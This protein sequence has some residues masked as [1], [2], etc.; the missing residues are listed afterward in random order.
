MAFAPQRF[1]LLRHRI[2]VE[3][4]KSA[5]NPTQFFT[6]LT[7]HFSTLRC[8]CILTCW[9]LFPFWLGHVLRAITACNFSLL[10]WP[11]GSA[12]RRFSEPT[13]RS[14]KTLEKYGVSRLCYLFA[15]LHLLTSDFLHL[16]SSHFWLSPCLSFFLAV[17]FHLSTL[18][19]VS[20]LIKLPSTRSSRQGERRPPPPPPDVHDPD[21]LWAQQPLVDAVTLSGTVLGIPVVATR[22]NSTW[23]PGAENYWNQLQ[24]PNFIRRNFIR[25]SSNWHVATNVCA[26]LDRYTKFWI[27][28][29]MPVT[30]LWSCRTQSDKPQDGIAEEKKRYKNWPATGCKIE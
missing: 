14:H 26:V 27:H 9:R 18:S 23:R 21:E 20:L 6:L 13:F 16:L 25:N 8:F 11:A 17:L 30:S 1:A 15:Y 29:D 10:I 3:S 28:V 2:A 12:P 19:D 4:S 7:S 22:D 24:E 5:P